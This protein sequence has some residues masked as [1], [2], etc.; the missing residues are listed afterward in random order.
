MDDSRMWSPMECVGCLCM[1]HSVPEPCPHQPSISFQIPSSDVS[2][3]LCSPKVR[4]GYPEDV[5]G[6][7]PLWWRIPIKALWPL[8][9]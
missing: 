7:V 5:E 6:W 9:A 4:I 2:L 3:V 8:P 1:I